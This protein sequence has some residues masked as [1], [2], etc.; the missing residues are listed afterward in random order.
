MEEGI[1]TLPLHE[2]WD[3]EGAAASDSTMPLC[4]SRSDQAC[5]LNVRGSGRGLGRKRKRH[6]ASSGGKKEIAKSKDEES[7]PKDYVLIKLG[8]IKTCI[9]VGW[10][11]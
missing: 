2:P 11:K 7:C 1:F 6:K 3:G 9:G 4:T 5:N 10:P 8:P